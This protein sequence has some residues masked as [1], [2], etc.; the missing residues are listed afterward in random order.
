MS[1]KSA[2]PQSAKAVH[3]LGLID[4][5]DLLPY[6][7]PAARD[8]KSITL[9]VTVDGVEYTRR[10]DR[11]IAIT[12]HTGTRLPF[13]H[14]WRSG[15]VPGRRDPA[16]LWRGHRQTNFADT[17]WIY[18]QA[19]K[20]GAFEAMWGARNFRVLTIAAGDETIV[21]LS[22]IV[23]RITERPLT[24]FFLFT[25]PARLFAEDPLAPIWFAPHDAY[26]HALNRYTLKA[27][28]SAVPLSILGRVELSFAF[29]ASSATSAAPR[30]QQ[31]HR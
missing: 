25:T 19:R 14:E 23:A 28:K 21:N 4:H 6:F 7:P 10:P 3:G 16:A 1:Q 11:L 12:D 27:L 31:T 30:A 2:L 9:S 29:N 20:A 22:R 8:P 26:D 5:H 13:A 17:V 18:W 15:E 24:K